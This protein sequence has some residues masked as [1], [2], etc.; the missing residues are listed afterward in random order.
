M[1]ENEKR[2]ITALAR[3]T[4]LPGSWAKKFV[5][6]MD[7]KMQDTPGHTLSDRQWYQI[8]TLYHSYRSQIPDHDRHCSICK[9]LANNEPLIKLVCPGCGHAESVILRPKFKPGTTKSCSH[10]SQFTWDNF[11]LQRIR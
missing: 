5:K 11:E 8:E 7:A 3:C 9:H 10:C 6:G 1:D 4:F 2:K